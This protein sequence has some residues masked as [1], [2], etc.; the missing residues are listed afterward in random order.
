[1]GAAGCTK[2]DAPKRELSAVL[3]GQPGEDT[4]HADAGVTQDIPVAQDIP[5]QPPHTDKDRTKDA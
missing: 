1:M 5:A 3:P 2:Q 4:G